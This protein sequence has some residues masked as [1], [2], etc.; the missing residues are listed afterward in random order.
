MKNGR[1]LSKDSIR[2]FLPFSIYKLCFEVDFV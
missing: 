2:L 1:T